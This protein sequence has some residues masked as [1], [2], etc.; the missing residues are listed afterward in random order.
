MKNRE[1]TMRIISEKDIDGRTIRLVQG[2]ITERN[3]D[4]VVN[5]ANSYLQHGGGVAG[6]LVRKGGQSYPG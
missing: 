2:D 5:A 6:A 1:D 4:A 3:V